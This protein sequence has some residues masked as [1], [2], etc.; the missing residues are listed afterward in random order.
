MVYFK[1]LKP[2]KSFRIDGDD[3]TVGRDDSCDVTIPEES[4]SSSHIRIEVKLGRFIAVDQRSC[5][6]LL[7]NGRKVRRASLKNGDVLQLGEAILRID[8]A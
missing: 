1:K 6:G 7:V 8:C 4:V 3:I 5:N 2:I